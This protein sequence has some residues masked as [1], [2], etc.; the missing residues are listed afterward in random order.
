MSRHHTPPPLV[1]CLCRR[2]TLISA[3]VMYHVSSWHAPL[4]CYLDPLVSLLYPVPFHIYK[5]H[6]LI[7]LQTV[8]LQLLCKP[9][10]FRGSTPWRQAL[11]KQIT[12]PT[13]RHSH[14]VTCVS[15]APWGETK[16]S[17]S[18]HLCKHNKQKKD[19]KNTPVDHITWQAVIRW[20]VL[21][22]IISHCKEGGDLCNHLYC[23]L[24][25]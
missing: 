24:Y 7:C 14:P 9:V 15:A 17:L 23:I 22:W 18:V 13:T 2:L 1:S 19:S 3:T 4:G 8:H 6:F 20:L 10:P 12:G 21:C 25:F 5:H 11:W 16:P